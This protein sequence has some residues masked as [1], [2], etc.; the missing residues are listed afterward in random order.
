MANSNENTSVDKNKNYIGKTDKKEPESLNKNTVKEELN[1]L[2]GEK[3]VILSFEERLKK[4]EERGRKRGRRYSKI[5]IIYSIVI[6]LAVLAGGYFLINQINKYADEA[7]ESME[8]ALNIENNL[9]RNLTLRNSWRGCFN[10][11]ECVETQKDCCACDAGG[12]QSA[13]N[14]NFV[15]L[16]QDSVKSRC[17]R[18]NCS[19][20]YNCKY[21]KAVCKN[22]LCEFEALYPGIDAVTNTPVISN[23]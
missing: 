13:I 12:I 7:N 4:L 6:C 18:S 1:K 11:N 15:G 22:N 3:S 21:G 14:S 16:W 23:E 19:N 20:T 17:S 2:S 8:R 5:G 10:D 9:S